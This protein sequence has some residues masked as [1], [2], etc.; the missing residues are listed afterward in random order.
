MKM[1]GMRMFE[2]KNF[3]GAFLKPFSVLKSLI[4]ELAA[5]IYSKVINFSLISMNESQKY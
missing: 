5:E 1:I 2:G 4:S 3:E